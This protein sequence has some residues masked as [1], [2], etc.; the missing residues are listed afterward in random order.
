MVELGPEGFTSVVMHPG[1]VQTDMGGPN[2]PLT[3]DESIASMLEVIDRLGP[4][5]NGR[6]LNYDGTT[7]PW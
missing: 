4:D 2:A 7:I 5:D 1:W 6:F 3:P